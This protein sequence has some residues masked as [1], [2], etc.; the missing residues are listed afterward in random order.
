MSL[1][2]HPDVVT[3]AIAGETLLVRA[4][5]GVADLEAI[6]VLD[7]VGSVIWDRLRAG[8]AP[9][10]IAAA[11]CAE[12]EVDSDQAQGDLHEFL[13]ALADARLLTSTEEVQGAGCRV[14]TDPFSP[15]TLS[16]EP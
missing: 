11:L 1:E 12:F 4:A 5:A 8:E 7:E 14:Q 10:A 13:T 9:P 15:S 16:P 6:Y 3:R 2:I